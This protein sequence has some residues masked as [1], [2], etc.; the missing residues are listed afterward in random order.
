MYSGFFNLHEKGF[1]NA[2]GGGTIDA[3]HKKQPVYN[4]GEEVKTN[5]HTQERTA[6]TQTGTLFSSPAY[7]LQCPWRSRLPMTKSTWFG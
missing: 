6:I 1:G 4:D 7:R 5:P 3:V 2:F